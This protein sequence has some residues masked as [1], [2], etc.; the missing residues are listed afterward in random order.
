MFAYPQFGK[1]SSCIVNYLKNIAEGNNFSPPS[2]RDVTNLPWKNEPADLGDGARLA[3]SAE[4]KHFSVTGNDVEN[5]RAFANETA[6]RG[7]LGIVVANDFTE[8]AKKLLE[9]IGLKAL[10]TDD[11]LR[12]VELW[13]PLKQRTAVA[14]LIYY[15]RHVEKN[16]FLSERIEAFVREASEYPLS[17]SPP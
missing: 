3:I 8:S 14:S 9:E 12:I 11:M 7:A 1:T 17:V 5:L 4:V 13:D 10:D 16:S 15:S 2:L 6:Q